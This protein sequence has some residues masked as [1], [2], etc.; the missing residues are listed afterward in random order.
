MFLLIA[1]SPIILGYLHT[2][3]AVLLP[4]STLLLI[5]FGAGLISEAGPLPEKLTLIPPA[6]VIPGAFLAAFALTTIV[7]KGSSDDVA[8]VWSRYLLYFP[9][10]ILAAVG[11]LRQWKR[12]ASSGLEAARTP[13]LI[14]SLAFLLNAVVAG[15]IVPRESVGLAPWLN[16]D[17]VVALTGVPVQ[18]WRAVAAVIVAICTVR[19]L[20][21]FE[22][23]RRREIAALQDQ[24]DNAQEQAL[25]VQEDARQ[26]AEKWTQSLVEI[27]GRIAGLEDVDSV[28]RLIVTHAR[29]LMNS[30][31]ATIALRDELGTDLYVK[32]YATANG[33]VLVEG[34]VPVRSAL[35]RRTVQAGQVCRYPEDLIAGAGPGEEIGRWV[36]PILNRELQAALVVPLQLDGRVFGGM[37]IGRYEGPSFAVEDSFSLQRLGDQTVIALEH[38]LMAAR[39]QSLAITE[40]RSRLAREMHDGLAQILGY[41]SLE[42]QTLGIL[43]QQNDRQQL[44][45]RLTKARAEIAE[46]HAEVRENILSLRTTLAGDIGLVPALQQYVDGFGEQTGIGIMVVNGVKGEPRI[47]PLAETHLVRI[48]QEALTNVRKHAH[49][50]HV[51]VEL[52][53]PNGHLAV[54]ISDDG[55]GFAGQPRDDHLG[56]RIMHERANSVGGT[57]AVR[58]RPGGGTEVHVSIPL[59]SD[60]GGKG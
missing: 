15:L 52:K 32:C 41:L 47:S 35:I 17:N 8:E 48:V 28:L 26:S 39:L 56:L 7:H 6:L 45:E 9:G 30:N 50:R 18:V 3:H 40:E 38:A 22:H 10:C 34:D 2:A 21:V 59:V 46:A 33:A 25:A 58:S 51:S 11:L 23:E 36:C 27:S 49:A 42:V 29:R 57:V 60:S 53:A 5:R 4:L 14:A 12:L 55:V 13:L 44:I 37:W 16:Y 19:T 54:I 31:T 1:E 20:D 43:A 24:R